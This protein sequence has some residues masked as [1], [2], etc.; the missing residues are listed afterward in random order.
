MSVFQWQSSVFF[1]YVL[2]IEVCLIYGITTTNIVNKEVTRVIDASTNVI[3]ISTTVKAII[4]S[5]RNSHS[6]SD[7]QAVANT[8]EIIFPN[9]HALNLAIISVQYKNKELELYEPTT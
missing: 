5:N 3:K 4:S 1:I 7:S 2:I 9:E 8:Y 6:N